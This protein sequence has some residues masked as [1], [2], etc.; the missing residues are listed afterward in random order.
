LRDEIPVSGH[1]RIERH[2]VRA[3]TPTP[4]AM[5]VPGLIDG[6]AVDPRPQAGVAAE[7]MDG[8]EDAKEDVLREVE[9]LVAVAE[10][11]DGQLNDHPLVLAQQFGKGSVFPGRT[12]L[13]KGGL[14]TPDV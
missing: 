10:Q 8:A 14:A 1:V 6:N 5:A 11:V 9:R 7:T 3:V 12:A 4:E 2:L 13:H